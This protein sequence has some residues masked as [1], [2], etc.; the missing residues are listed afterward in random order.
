MGMEER[1]GRLDNTEP[2][3]TLSFECSEKLLFDKG[4]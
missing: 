2:Y 4:E 1:V 3:Q